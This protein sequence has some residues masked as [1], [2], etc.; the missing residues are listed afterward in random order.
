MI[1]AV[2]NGARVEA[3]EVMMASCVAESLMRIYLGC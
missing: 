3:L 2:R 1:E